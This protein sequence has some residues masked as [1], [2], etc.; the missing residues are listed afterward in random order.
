MVKDLPAVTGNDRAV[1]TPKGFLVRERPITEKDVKNVFDNAAL[2]KFSTRNIKKPTEDQQ[3]FE[4]SDYTNIEAAVYQEVREAARGSASALTRLLDRTV[5][6]VVQRTANTNVNVSLV[7]FL[8]SEDL[9]DATDMELAEAGIVIDA[10]V[11]N[12]E[13]DYTRDL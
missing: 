9:N 1:C 12:A 11:I 5:G 7:E 6:P 8:Q 13:E 3:E 2:E 10:E 4:A